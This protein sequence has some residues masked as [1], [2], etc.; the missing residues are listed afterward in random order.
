MKDLYFINPVFTKKTL[1]LTVRRG[2][3]WKDYIDEVK[4]KDTKSK[5]EIANGRIVFSESAIFNELTDRDL[6]LEH[7]IECR[8]KSGLFYVMSQLYEGFSEDE[9]VILIYFKVN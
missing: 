4:I 5:T 3:K 8:T 9:E 7:D 2:D 6:V 1:N